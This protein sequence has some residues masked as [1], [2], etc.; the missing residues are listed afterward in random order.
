MGRMVPA[1]SQK[2]LACII[3]V[4]F[5]P[6]GIEMVPVCSRGWI[7]RLPRLP[8]GPTAVTDVGI[9]GIEQELPPIFVMGTAQRALPFVPSDITD[10][11][12]RTVGVHGGGIGF[13]DVVVVGIVAGLSIHGTAVVVAK[14]IWVVVVELAGEAA[15][16]V[17]P[18][19]PVPQ[20]VRASARII[21][22]TSTRRLYFTIRSLCR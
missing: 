4:T 9:S 16:G 21:S 11:T 8:L 19:A 6:D 2:S 22:A 20:A 1:A 17:V 3:N 7:S 5:V 15:G 18:L 12:V 10:P 13:G 14:P